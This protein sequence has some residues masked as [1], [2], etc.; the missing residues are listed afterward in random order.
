MNFCL[1][2]DKEAEIANEETQ[3]HDLEEK[4]KGLEKQCREENKNMGG[5]SK[6]REHVK[7]TQHQNRILENRLDQALKKFNTQ[8]VRNRSLRENIDSHRVER[9]R[10]DALCER[11][12]KALED[13]KKEKQGIIEGSTL[14]Y[15]SRDEAQQKMVVLREKAEKDRQQYEAEIKELQRL[16]DHDKKLKE[17]MGIKTQERK[18]DSQQLWWK[19]KKGMTKFFVINNGFSVFGVV[20]S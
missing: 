4:I 2:E 18:E 6:A 16:L 20:V 11:L 9:S 15:E 19:Q 13:L 12:E 5:A 1:S 3:I 10:Y 8:L 17:F 14:A 7:K